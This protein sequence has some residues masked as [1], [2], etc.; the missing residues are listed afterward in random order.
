[1]PKEPKCKVIF[2]VPFLDKPTAPFIAALEA[3]IPLIEAA[4]W[5]HGLV[6]E[7]G[8]VYISS[9]RNTMLRKALNGVPDC[10]VFLD[11]DLSWEPPD[12]LTLIQTEGEV[13]AGT[14]R[15]KTDDTVE[16]MADHL[17]FNGLPLARPDGC[18]RAV[19]IPAGFLKITRP[20]VNRFMAA[21]P[22]LVYGDLC[23]P[24]V[25]LFN[26][27]AMD[28]VWYGEDYG[29][30][31]HWRDIGGEIW[32]RPDL[33]I[34]H[35]STDK[36]YPGNFHEWLMSKPGGS[37]DPARLKALEAMSNPEVVALLEQLKPKDIA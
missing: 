6:Q 13:V 15:F 8:N 22:Q 4:G 33:N 11:Y 5:D 25:D 18:I 26:H 36:A 19:N 10:V 34:T 37:K 3:S 21:Y 9:A 31:K 35:H 28:R 12:L 27:G 17:T 29:F 23:Y 2:C 32:L 16:Y 30:C 24:Y 14:Y 20:A 1:M 7:R